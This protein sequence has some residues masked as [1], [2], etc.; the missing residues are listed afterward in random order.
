MCVLTDH[1]R[2][3][4]RFKKLSDLVYLFDYEGGKVDSASAYMVRPLLLIAQALFLP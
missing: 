2:N 4:C 3:Y 1:S